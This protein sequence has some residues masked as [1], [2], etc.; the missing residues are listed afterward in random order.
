MR[1]W[2]GQDS[3]AHMVILAISFGFTSIL[4]NISRNGILSLGDVECSSI[5]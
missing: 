1:V 5:K 2:G 4:D 3:L